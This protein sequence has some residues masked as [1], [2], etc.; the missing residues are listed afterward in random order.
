M[1][2]TNGNL[3]LMP[4]QI[5]TPADW[6]T[7]EKLALLRE[8]YARGLT[9]PEFELFIEHCRQI[10]LNPLT[11]QVQPVKFDGKTLSFH[12][13]IHGLVAIASRTG[14]Y[15]G[16]D[17]V[18]FDCEPKGDVLGNQ[19]P[20]WARATVY[21]LVQGQLR[22]AKATVRWLERN[23][24]QAS[25]KVQPWHMLGKCALAAAFRL[26]FEETRGLYIEEEL[27]PAPVTESAAPEPHQAQPAKAPAF[28][29]ERVFPI[30]PKGITW[31][32]H[33]E[34][35]GKRLGIYAN[36]GEYLQHF[37][38]VTKVD[39]KSAT[40]PTTVW[41]Q[42]AEHLVERI[43]ALEAEDAELAEAQAEDEA[44]LA[45]MAGLD[46]QA[47]DADADPAND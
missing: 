6:D 39:P 34:A 5:Q 14:R 30:P 43:E 36:L 29:K 33:C 38:E 16:V 35:L 9:Q 45:K 47:V 13:T 32:A 23:R 46:A 11:K 42:W 7:A 21:Y 4:R 12:T 17:D 25:W 8:T 18:E 1:S 15:A 22:Y 31:K 24:G 3:A 40:I 19:H 27:P 28:G 20:N 10:G 37:Q 2:D 41:K 26:A 44:S